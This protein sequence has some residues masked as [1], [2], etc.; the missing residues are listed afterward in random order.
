M[1]GIEGKRVAVQLGGMDDRV[2]PD[3]GSAKLITNM[4]WSPEGFW[5]P[6]H[7]ALEVSSFTA[8]SGAISALHWFAPRPNQR[9]LIV[10]R[11]I[12][13]ITSRISYVDFPAGGTPT[14]ILDRRRLDSD[15]LGT[16]FLDQGRWC[17]M[18]SPIDGLVRWNGQ[19]V[20]PVGFVSPAPAPEV[21]VTGLA[22]PFTDIA[23]FDFSGAVAVSD[24]NQ[25]GLGEFPA[26]G[27]ERWVYAYAA[28]LLNDLGQESPPSPITVVSGAND[29]TFG[30][31]FALLHYPRSPDHIRGVRIW[32]S[33]N[34]VGVA[35]PSDGVAL[36][37]HSEW[38]TAGEFDLL[39]LTDDTE[40]VSE[41]LDRDALG[42]VPVGCRVMASWADAT[43]LGGSSEFP[44]RLHFSTAG[45]P[46][47]FG[48]LSYL[49]IGTA[50]TGPIVALHPMQRGL[51]VLKSGGIYI[52][53][54][55]HAQGFRWDEIDTSKGCAAPRAVVTV[56]K[57]G[58]LF[59]DQGAGPCAVV[60]SLDDDRPTTVEPIGAGI[61]KFWRQQAGVLLTQ[62]VV[63]YDAARDEVWWALPVGGNARNSLGLALHVGITAWSVRTGWD[64][65]AFES[66]KG[67]IW[68]GSNND[69]D[70][71]GV[72]LLTAA[73]RTRIDGTE[74]EG[75]YTTNP[76]RQGGDAWR[77][78]WVEGIG[79]AMGSR[80]EVAVRTDRGD[81]TP[82]SET[83]PRQLQQSHEREQWGKARW[84]EGSW[85][86]YDVAVMPVSVR[87]GFGFEQAV[88]IS[89]THFRMSAINLVLPVEK[90]QPQPRPSERR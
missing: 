33:R 15:D 36:Y 59:L 11:R 52:V 65:G 84:N 69:T 74:I 85:T 64:I 46:E 43:W 55:N 5:E 56:P 22:S 71:P 20:V 87:V 1:S 53:K 70:S 25:R 77:F 23:G 79:L 44:H 26:S 29:A 67:A 18:L 39:D 3:E 28:T 78:L 47:Q 62:A 75:V 73:R 21:T 35:N 48:P 7:G 24:Q 4:Q 51:L 9:W 10:E 41:I 8:G 30:R 2:V 32:R 58:V 63:T 68:M 57:V 90:G 31:H 81:T 80:W 13:E 6:V 45:F 38:A 34:L 60:G 54:G 37:L 40:L 19:R 88:R 61:R 12:D 86:D 72:F 82:Q 49:D 27:A 42:P 14:T 17:W 50:A 66:Y 89:S 16:Q 76:L 83:D